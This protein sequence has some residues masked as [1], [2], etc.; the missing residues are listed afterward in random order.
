MKIRYNNERDCLETNLY[1]VDNSGKRCS[2]IIRGKTKEILN[3]KINKLKEEINA[4]SLTSPNLTLASWFEYYITYIA[5][6]NNRESTVALKRRIF[7]SFPEHIK[8]SAMNSITTEMLQILLNELY[9]KYS[10]NTVAFRIE[11]LGILFN[12]AME[13]NKI[14]KNPMKHLQKKNFEVGKKVLV[15]PKDI[16]KIIQYTNNNNLICFVLLTYYS[17]GRLNEVL[18]LKKTDID[19]DKNIVHFRYQYTKTH[20]VVK[21][22]L[23]L[24]TAKSFRSVKIPRFVVE[25]VK[26]L[27]DS[28]TSGS[29]YILNYN[30]NLYTKSSFSVSLKRLF[31]RSGYPE[32]SAKQLRSSF[33]KNAVKKNISLKTLQ[34]ILG[35]SKFSTTA[36][37]YGNIESEDTYYVA[38]AMETDSV[39]FK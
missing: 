24:K 18:S 3:K 11:L 9:K 2:R 32:L 14:D 20:N 26:A 21:E 38:D 37:I 13:R 10:I 19:F 6:I 36:D 29:C 7:K 12:L 1:F 5:P 30:G 17:A 15:S 31:E 4:G 25:K 16:S 35:H 34:Q 27:I 33:V 22:N 8:N 39:M 28:D 23:P